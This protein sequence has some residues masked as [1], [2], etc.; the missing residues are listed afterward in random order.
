M[1]FNESLQAAIAEVQ[2]LIGDIT[3]IAAAPE[4]PNDAPSGQWPLSIAFPRGG[5]FEGG[6]AAQVVGYHTIV[7]Q[8]HYARTDLARAYAAIVPYLEEIAAVVLDDPTLAAT[9]TTVTA[10]RHSFG[11]MIYAAIDTIGWQFEIDVK[12]RYTE[13]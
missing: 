6:G 2:D 1:S 8:L 5:S 13:A 7:V 9:V 3:G 4:N 11:G 12:I 10:F